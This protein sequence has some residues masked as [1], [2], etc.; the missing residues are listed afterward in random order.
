VA[1]FTTPAHRGGVRSTP[2]KE[3]RYPSNGRLGGPQRR[4]EHFGVEKIFLFSAGI[5]NRSLVTIPTTLSPIPIL[6]NPPSPERG[7]L[8]QTKN[9]DIRRM[10]GKVG[11]RDELNILE[12][13][14]IFFFL[15]GFEPVA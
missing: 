6:H 9:P 1:N 13:K 10:G 4:S 15:P 7:A 14:I 8:P 11:P 2:D 5:R 3:S 12:K